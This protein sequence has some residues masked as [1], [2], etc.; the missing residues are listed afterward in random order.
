LDIR[1]T[2]WMR[3]ADWEGGNEI[4]AER[5]HS[6]LTSEESA[7]AAGDEEFPYFSGSEGGKLDFAQV[8]VYTTEHQGARHASEEYLI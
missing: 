8:L 5:D 3:V 6:V 7:D 1:V 4:G 2:E